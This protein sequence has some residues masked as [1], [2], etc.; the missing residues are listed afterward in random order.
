MICTSHPILWDDKIG[1]NEIDGACSSYG[2]GRGFY[3][4][5]VGKAEGRRPLGTPRRRREYNIKMDL[6]E[7]ECGI[8]TGLSWLRIG[9]GGGHL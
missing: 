3:R 7:V 1:K 6:Q 9:T 5:L 2:E 4:V 8:W